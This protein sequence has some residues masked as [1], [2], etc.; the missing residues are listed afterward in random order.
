MHP[1]GIHVALWVLD[2]RNLADLPAL[3]RFLS[4][5][6][7]ARSGRLGGA[8]Q[9]SYIASHAMVRAAVAARSGMDPSEIGFTSRCT[10]CG[11][12]THGKPRLAP[13]P[14]CGPVEVSLSRTAGMVAL[15]LSN[16]PVGI[17]VEHISSPLSQR[18]LAQLL[19]PGEMGDLSIADQSSP[20]W[21]CY[22]AWVAKEAVGKVRGSG[23]VGMRDLRVVPPSDTWR[24][25][26]DG[27]ERWQVRLLDLGQDHAGALATPAGPTVVELL[28]PRDILSAL[29]GQSG[30]G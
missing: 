20:R 30:G 25:V 21:A 27:T 10:R 2:A 19:S 8:D 4:A 24:L 22:Q 9:L 28:D 3:P 12:P 29:H 11:H 14:P 16:V 13:A 1:G 18:D 23:L 17:D 5:G 15:A 26:V 6:E 7:R